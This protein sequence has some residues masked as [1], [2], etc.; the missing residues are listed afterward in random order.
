MHPNSRLRATAA[1]TVAA[2]A[3]ITWSVLTPPFGSP[4]PQESAATA[5]RQLPRPAAPGATAATPPLTLPIAERVAANEAAEPVIVSTAANIIGSKWQSQTQ[6]ECLA[7]SNWATRYI[8]TPAAERKGMLTEGVATATARREMLVKMIRENP[9]QALAAAVPVMVR[10]ELPAQVTDLLEERVSGK[11]SISTLSGTPVPGSGNVI[12]KTRHALIDRSEYE[13]FPYGRRATKEDLPVVSVLGIALDGQ[14]AVSDSPIRVLEPGETA[15]G[16]KV[17]EVCLISGDTTP[18]KI[19]GSLNTGELTAVETNGMIQMVC[20]PAHISKLEARLISGEG[21][22]ANGAP[23]SSTV[24]GRPSYAFTHGPKTTLVVRVDFS[25]VPGTPKNDAGTGNTDTVTPSYA[26]QIYNEANG[27]KDFFEQNSYGQTTLVVS[28]AV[29]DVS[30][31]V[32]P[33]FR[34][35]STASSYV[36]VGAAGIGNADLLHSDAR[37]LASAAGY[38]LANY[39]KVLVSYSYL[40]NLPGSKMTFAG[41][42]STPGTNIWI[43]GYYKM[44]VIAHETGHTYGMNH[45]SSWEVTDGNPVSPTGTLQEYGDKVDVM[46]D[47]STFSHQFSHWNRSLVQWMPDTAVTTIDSGGTYRVHRFDS[48]SANLANPLA[49]KVVRNRTQD[50][51]IGYRR[52][53]SNEN[54]NN[55]AYIVWGANQNTNSLLLDMNTPGNT[56]DDAPLAVGQSFN[57][58]AAGI[59]LKTLARGGSGADEYL[60]VQVTFLPRVA[61]TSSSFGADEQSGTAAL[62]LTRSNNSVGAVSVHWATA[63]GTATSPADFTASSGD[64]TWANGDSADKTINIPL[65]AD[66]LAEGSENFTVTL[67]AVTGGGVLVDAPAA[68][69]NIVDPGGVDTSL[70]ADFINSS[71]TKTLVQ[72]DGKILIAGPFSSLE[73]QP[74]HR[75]IARVDAVGAVDTAFATA[76]GAGTGTAVS[77]MARQPDGKI[78]VCGDFTTMN[79]VA[80]NGVAR[81]NVDGSLDTTFDPG[82]GAD[83]TVDAILAQPDGK[84]L[85]GGRFLNIA[86]SPREYLARLNADGSLDTGFTGPNFGGTSGW[87]VSALALQAD[88]KL[89]VAGSFYISGGPSSICRVTTTG[90]L[91]ATFNGPVNG[92]TDVASFFFLNSIDSIAVQLDGK[93]LIAGSFGA[94]NTV[95]RGGFARLT[96]TGALDTAFPA[97]S[98]GDCRAILIQP[99]GKILVGGTFTTFDGVPAAHTV[100][101][102]SAGAVDTVFGAA[103]GPSANVNALAMQA[104]GRIVFG[105]DYGNFQGLTD[106][107]LYRMF[108]GLPALPGTIQFASATAAAGEGSSAVLSVTRTGGSA[109]VLSVNYSTVTGTAGAGD[110]TTTSFGTLSWAN[111]DAAAK[112]ITIPIT[113]DALAEGTE[114]FSVNLG[115]PLL[116]GA[117][118]GATQSA[119]VSISDPGAITAYQTWREAKFTSAELLIAAVSGDFADPDSD[120]IVNLLEFAQGL[121]PKTSGQVGTPVVGKQVV[122]GSTYLTLTFRRQI[123]APELTYTA[124]VN[125]S[126]SATWAGGA[127]I[128]GSP[129]SNGDGTETVTYRDTVAQTAANQRFMRLQVTLAP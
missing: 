60:D 118:L 35:P 83:N 27:V 68:T 95:P 23:G 75:G 71:V 1:V 31:D 64:V 11:G 15:D 124:Q 8:A 37:A 86:G 93:I 10:K 20:K 82:T 72:P 43:T 62:T 99:D 117:I 104:D 47:G 102:T 81:L 120:G 87:S 41:L 19:N 42:G 107:P 30:P 91:D 53:T 125:G 22:Q 46:G 73:G 38:N 79:G 55:G 39:D 119:T 121:A 98:D 92:A 76:G 69:V 25:D 61:W 89:L 80:R 34:M 103:A 17:E 66:A 16:K 97:T 48:P 54:Y 94:Y 56:P 32:T 115:Q 129:V 109:G 26:A 70:V 63:P 40:G 24:S 114:T 57:D 128:V 78:L 28:P 100:R 6:A 111:G 77:D 126:L 106:H 85:I 123:A 5:P 58:T 88:G 113:T 59:T 33:V 44:N 18:V 84:V 4:S 65:V 12:A 105:S 36:T 67:S 108:S 49:L 112:T 110:F 101:L 13:A 127:V 90:A 9:E 2:T 21:L 122:G 45:A 3:A 116:G 74:V 96:S 29:S 52:A 7:F 51:W 14:L 50:Y